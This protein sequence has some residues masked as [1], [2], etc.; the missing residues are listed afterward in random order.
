MIVETADRASFGE[1]QWRSRGWLCRVD[2]PTYGAGDRASHG[3]P[4]WRLR[5]WR[6]RVDDPTY[7]LR[8]EWWARP[9]LQR[10]DLNEG[11]RSR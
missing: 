8:D 6:C 5:W 2:D 3:K 9:T 1:L 4:Q 7:S 11:I 10:K